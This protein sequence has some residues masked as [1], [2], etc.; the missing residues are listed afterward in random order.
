MQKKQHK[1]PKPFLYTATLGISILICLFS[2][3]ILNQVCSML[4]KSGKRPN[5]YFL[6]E[7]EIDNLSNQLVLGRNRTQS[8]IFPIQPFFPEKIDKY[9]APFSPTLLKT[10]VIDPPNLGYY[11][12]LPFNL[13][14][15]SS[16][17][18]RQSTDGKMVYNYSVN[19]DKYARRDTPLNKESRERSKFLI[20]AGCSFTFGEGLNDNE[21][22][23]FFSGYYS[24]HYHSYNYGMGG[25]SPGDVLIRLKAI[26][27]SEEISEKS[28]WVIYPYIDDHLGR[29]TGPMSVVGKW[30]WNKLHFYRSK[31]GQIQYDGTFES[32]MPIKTNLYRLLA[33]TN[34]VQYFN[35]DIPWKTTN[36]NW[37]FLTQVI[38]QIKVLAKLKFNTNNFAV[39]FYP[40]SNTSRR[41]IPFLERYHIK[42]I[43]F[44]H[45]DVNSLTKGH[46]WI[47]LDG[48]PSSE[49]NRLIAKTL[50]RELEKLDGFM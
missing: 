14:I 45:W 4:I 16:R 48:H 49:T 5:L 32:V 24:S 46:P 18:S 39:L 44:S 38:E 30:A 21:T 19:I 12:N 23:P 28:G 47:P 3:L 41:L 20:F 22:L 43:D 17:I 11:K 10:R 7:L 37:E 9:P 15:R 2:I 50:V 42:Y 8:G 31:D 1:T 25:A 26:S 36:D 13:M 33:N 40:G 6:R 27:K 34:I 29:L 35:I